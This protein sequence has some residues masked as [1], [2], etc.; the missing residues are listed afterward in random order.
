MDFNSLQHQSESPVHIR[1]GSNPNFVPPAGFDYPLDGLLP[2]TPSKLF[3]KPA[4]LLGFSPLRSLTF[5]NGTRVS[6]LGCPHIPL[7][8]VLAGKPTG[9]LYSRL[10]GTTHRRKP[11]PTD[12]PEFVSDRKLP[13]GSPFQGMQ[14]ASFDPREI[15]SH[16]LGRHC[17]SKIDRHHRVSISWGWVEV[18]LRTM[19]DFH[20]PLKVF[21]PFHSRALR[22]KDTGLL[23][24]PH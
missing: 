1:W 5:H 15:S 7:N 24:S 2:A 18:S 3:F 11:N 23:N 21:A 17:L 19:L 12:K 6:P 16:T 20:N 22:P 4:A 13:W 10:L 14:P 8:R 9:T